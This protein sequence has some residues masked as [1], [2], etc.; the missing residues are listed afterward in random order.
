MGTDAEMLIPQQFKE[1]NILKNIIKFRELEN[2]LH[3]K[4][5]KFQNM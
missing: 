1:L 2:C 4:K 5:I 3:D